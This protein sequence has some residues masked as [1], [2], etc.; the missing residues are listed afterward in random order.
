MSAGLSLWTTDKDIKEIQ[1][2]DHKINHGHSLYATFQHCL[3]L[4]FSQLQTKYGKCFATVGWCSC[5][6]PPE[7]GVV[8]DGARSLQEKSL[9]QFYRQK[10]K[11]MENAFTNTWY[12]ALLWCDQIGQ[13]LLMCFINIL[14]KGQKITGQVVNNFLMVKIFFKNVYFH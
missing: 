5:W 8:L 1:S 9:P 10:K 6:I 4:S 11:H 13:C 14:F 2:I 12:V 7:T 3:C